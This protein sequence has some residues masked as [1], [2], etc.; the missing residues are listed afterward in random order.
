M[1][2][3]PIKIDDS[4]PAKKILENENVFVMTN[5]QAVAQDIRPVKIIILNLMPIK[6]ETETHLLRLLSNTP[7]QVDIELL[8][9]AS[10]KSKNTSS[11]YLNK[12]YKTF[13]DIKY[14]KYDGMIVT[15]APVEK[16]DFEQVDY[17]IELCSIMEWSKYNVYSA[18]HICWGAQAALYYH[19]SIPKIL[20]NNKI[21]GI[22]NQKTIEIH[23][24]IVRGFDE[25]FPMPHSRYADINSSDVIKNENL[26]IIAESKESGIS[27]ISNK[28]GR[29]IFITGHLEYQRET[30]ANE[31]FR[32]IKRGLNPLIPKNY[33]PNND[34]LNTPII[35]WSSHAN[36]LFSNWLNYF[37][38]QATPYDIAKIQP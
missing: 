13:D 12:F 37:V 23:H 4:L 30:L 20:V 28:D 6:S 14:C 25:F 8:Q 38:Y 22:Y 7:L 10:H 17:W 18:L 29:Q 36:L 26:R 16:L 33:F 34:P 27:I 31:Y 11:E 9:M 24:P 2:E 32:D 3:M 21:S 35:T 5:K 15:G 1:N 19:Y